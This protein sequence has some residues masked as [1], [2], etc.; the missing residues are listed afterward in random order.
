MKWFLNYADKG[1]FEAQTFGI[2]SALKF[3]FDV[4]MPMSR[5]DLDAEFLGKYDH[6]LS[7]HRGAGYWLWKPYLILKVLNMAKDG[8][9]V[10]YGDSGTNFI[11][12]VSYLITDLE[13]TKQPIMAFDL[14]QM[15][16]RWWTKM[17]VFV[18]NKCEDVKY[19]D[20]NICDAAHQLI[21]KCD[22]S[23]EFYNEYFSQCCVEN[24]ITDCPNIY[25][26]PNHSEFKDHRHDQSIFS[27]NIKK[28]NYLTFRTPSQF[29]IDF[30]SMYEFSEYPQVI[31]HHRRK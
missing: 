15:P 23:M 18:Y 28:K 24:L 27:I 22:E 8:D 13:K 20:S 26:K 19:M 4:A 14:Q 6:I 12:D 30:K 25:G 17:D 21:R 16:E 11:D 7:Q 1:F 2:T 10:Y 5:K 31:N 3:G 9:Y 29:G